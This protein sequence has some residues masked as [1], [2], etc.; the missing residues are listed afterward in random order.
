MES[1][2]NEEIDPEFDA[3]AKEYGDEVQYMRLNGTTDGLKKIQ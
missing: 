3:F 2:I 1:I